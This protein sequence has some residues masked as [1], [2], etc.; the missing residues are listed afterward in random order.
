MNQTI[1]ESRTLKTH[2]NPVPNHQ[3]VDEISVESSTLP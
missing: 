3:T 2:L 1:N